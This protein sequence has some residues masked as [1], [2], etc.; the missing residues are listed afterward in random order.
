MAREE[1]PYLV[2]N[3]HSIEPK[4]K[5]KP[6]QPKDRDL[7]SLIFQERLKNPSHSDAEIQRVAEEKLA[8]IRELP[9]I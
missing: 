9:P 6:Q 4:P 3:P 2:R 5:E 8:V 1:L 7:Q